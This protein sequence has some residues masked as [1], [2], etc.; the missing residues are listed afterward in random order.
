MAL[1][2]HKYWNSPT[3][4]TVNPYFALRDTWNVPIWLGESGENGNEWFKQTL[5]M[6]ES[7]RI[8][9]SWWPY[10]KIES[11]VGPVSVSSTPGWDAFVAWGKGGARP[12]S[13]SLDAGL[14]DLARNL[15]I[16]ESRVGRDVL[17]AM[18]RQVR[19]DSAKPWSDIRVPGSFAAVEYDLG[20]DGT[21]YHDARSMNVG[22]KDEGSWNEGWS[23]RNDG[24]DIQ[25][26]NEERAWN[27]GWI[28]VGEWLQY[29]V[30][31][32]TTTRW[33][34]LART[35][36]QGG[37]FAIEVDGQPA[38]Q[39]AARTTADWW[40]WTTSASGSFPMAAGKRRIRV[41]A[42]A[43][44]SNIGK[45]TLVPAHWACLQD[46]SCQTVGD[47]PRVPSAKPA[48]VECTR[49]GI[50]ST[51]SRPVDLLVRDAR[52]STLLRTTLAPGG[53]VATGRL[54]GKGLH[55]VSVDGQERR[56]V[57]P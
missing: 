26:S 36:G 57:R 39:M 2:F 29:T 31:A 38:A 35:A 3:V 19:T 34:L 22:V 16:E 18:F 30:Q 15:R 32:D 48:A 5:K 53:F 45:L 23:F 13:A 54:L 8:G 51:S 21:A 47:S 14:M 27:L 55:L 9:W 43:S 11:V 17:D 10:K 24:V 33:V 4:G 41:L 20:G 1:S 25:W 52:G 46:G 12:D 49:E 44:G 28:E 50:R 42:T 7:E 56:I 6:L 37:T 40:T